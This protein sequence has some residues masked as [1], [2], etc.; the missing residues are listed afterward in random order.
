MGFAAL[1]AFSTRQLTNQG[2]FPRIDRTMDLPYWKPVYIVVF[3]PLIAFVAVVLLLKLYHSYTSPAINAKNNGITRSKV[4]HAVIAFACALIFGAGL[5]ISG[6]CSP[7]RVTRFLDF[8][9]PDGWDPSLI[10]VMAG[11]V[12]FNTITFHV[13]HRHEARVVVPEDPNDTVTLNNVIKLWKHPANTH[14]PLSFVSGAAMFGIGWGMC[15]ICPGPGLVNIG[16]A[17]R[18]SAVFLPFLLIGMAL[19]E[20]YKSWPIPRR[21][22]AIVGPDVSKHESVVNEIS[23]SHA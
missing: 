8:S 9:G 21:T 5:A 20:V 23:A 2:V 1:S 16:A 22:N 18:V 4:Q 6:M 14:I 17:S 11:G 15:G 12:V 7:E 19:H 13:L 10:G 3:L